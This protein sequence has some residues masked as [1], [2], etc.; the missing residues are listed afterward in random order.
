MNLNKSRDYLKSIKRFP[1][2]ILTFSFCLSF[3]IFLS[4]FY[5]S[6]AFSLH[7][8]N[9]KSLS[10]ISFD[11]SFPSCFVSPFCAF[12]LA[13]FLVFNV[14]HF[15]IRDERFPASTLDLSVINP[16]QYDSHKKYMI[17]FK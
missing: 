5:F 3:A 14:T 7:K 9:S 10:H 12:F 6:L 11:R 16:C 4:Q 13:I 15:I 17:F 1:T 8:W 2:F